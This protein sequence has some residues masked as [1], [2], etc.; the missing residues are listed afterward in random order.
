MKHGFDVVAV[1][2]DQE[3]CIV[4]RVIRAL[5]WLTIAHPAG[6]QPRAM[7]AVDHFTIGSL[8]CQMHAASQLALRSSALLVETNSSSAQK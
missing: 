1:G 2:V 7:K 5:A 3:C 6:L 8:K 4:A